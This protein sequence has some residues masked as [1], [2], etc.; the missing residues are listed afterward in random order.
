MPVILDNFSK[1]LD[2]T[3]VLVKTI[4]ERKIKERKMARR[5]TR[6]KKYSKVISSVIAAVFLLLG[7]MQTQLHSGN[8]AHEAVEI[9][10]QAPQ[11]GL[12]VSFLDVGQ[13]N[14]I[15]VQNQGKNLII[16][17][18]N[19]DKSSFVVSYLQQQGIQSFDYV[20]ASHYDADHISG[21]VGVLSVFDC[22]KVLDPDYVTDSKI[23]Q[24]FQQMVNDKQVRVEHPIRG[25]TYIFG[26]T[27]IQVVAPDNFT[28]TEE[29]DRSIGVR[30]VYKN[31]SFLICADAQKESEEAMIASGENLKS[32]VYLASHHG[33]GHSSSEEFLD[34]VDPSYVVISAGMGNS[35]GHPAKETVERLQKR[36]VSLFRT[37][38][39][40]TIIAYSDGEKVTFAQPASND[41]SSG[42]ELDEK[43]R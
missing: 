34:K 12:K 35:Y 36:N 37:D 3:Y 31:T 39:Q 5:R 6:R 23:Y 43:N 33:S 16:D 41:F 22:Q 18:G 21:L 13:G 42:E 2:R 38:L 28:A 4:L 40:G 27:T 7:F 9:S 14:C 26:D 32:D 19:R 29:N 11:E 20:I 25:S 30:I 1:K 24:S 8:K 10:T 15:L 17:G